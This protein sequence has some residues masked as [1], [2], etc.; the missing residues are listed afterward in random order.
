MP[1]KEDVQVIKEPLSSDIVQVDRPASFPSMPQ[2][3]LELFENKQKIKQNLVNT[4]YVPDP[5]NHHSPSP[6]QEHYEK[7]SPRKDP[8]E[9]DFT[10]RI[11]DLLD[12]SDDED[13]YHSS[14]KH[15]S[16]VDH[17]SD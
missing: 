5:N 10:R 2:L 4:E 9:N 12:Q 1:K 6:V 3:Y 16:S 11:N 17:D 15:R 8:E 14:T 13:K 7:D